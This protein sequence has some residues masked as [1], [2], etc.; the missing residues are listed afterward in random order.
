MKFKNKTIAFILLLSLIFT[1]KAFIVFAETKHSLYND[2]T[3]ITVETTDDTNVTSENENTTAAEENKESESTNETTE[4]SEIIETTEVTETETT[5]TESSEVSNSYKSTTITEE[6]ET[7]MFE[8]TTEEID[9]STTEEEEPEEDITTVAT[10]ETSK[11]L[12]ETDLS[13]ESTTIEETTAKIKNNENLFGDSTPQFKLVYFKEDMSDIDIYTFD[14]AGMSVIPDS[15]TIAANELEALN[16]YD[17]RYNGV[18]DIGLEGDN[19]AWFR[20]NYVWN[21]DRIYSE[22]PISLSDAFN[23]WCTSSTLEEKVYGA[24]YA[25]LSEMTIV[26]NTIDTEYNMGENFNP[27]GLRID[28]KFA[29]DATDTIEYSD[30]TRNRFKFYDNSTGDELTTDTEINADFTLKIVYGDVEHG[31]DAISTVSATI[32][33]IT[34]DPSAE[35]GFKVYCQKLDDTI[36]C[37]NYQNGTSSEDFTDTVRQLINGDSVASDIIAYQGWYYLNTY[38]GN[39]YEAYRTWNDTDVFSFESDFKNKVDEWLDGGKTENKSVGIILQRRQY[40]DDDHGLLYVWHLDSNGTII[41]DEFT[42]IVR[43]DEFDAY[44]DELNNSLPPQYNTITGYYRDAYIDYQFYRPDRRPRDDYPPLRDTFVQWKE[45]PNSFSFH[46]SKKLC[47]AYERKTP[48]SISVSTPPNK[49]TYQ[50]GDHF[51]PEGLIITASYPGNINDQVPCDEF[52]DFLFSFDPTTDV[53]LSTTND[54]ITITCCN[55]SVDLPIYVEPEVTSISICK[56]VNHDTYSV[57]E[58]LDPSGLSININYVDATSRELVYNDENASLFDFNPAL[59]HAYEVSDVGVKSHIITYRS[60][61]TSFNINVLENNKFMVLYEAG[62]VLHTEVLEASASNIESVLD[63]AIQSGYTG[64]YKF[65]ALGYYDSQNKYDKA[66]EQTLTKEQ[67]LLLYKSFTGDENIFIGAVIKAPTPTPPEPTPPEPTPDPTPTPP[68]NPGG[69]GGSSGGSSSPSKGP[70]GDLTKQAIPTQQIV[71]S[72]SLN[73]T[74]NIPQNSLVDNSL[75]AVTLLSVPENEIIPKTNITDVNGNT[76][77]G[78]WLKVP[79]E[80]TWFFLAGD[81]SA[82]GN[83]GTAGFVSNGLYNLSWGTSNGW[84]S[85]DIFGAMQTGWQEINGKRYYFEPNANEASFGMAVV[86]TKTIDGKSYSFDTNGVL[87]Q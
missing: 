13:S 77:F 6:N 39:D 85:F 12:K 66:K 67:A 73:P 65:D 44:I 49:T 72:F 35:K 86:G 15:I 17:K 69:G 46:D 41:R 28:V 36:E 76:G 64:F 5:E 60:K 1:S 21:D 3:T 61:E 55:K 43:M 14:Y 31:N 62:N 79:N 16:Y 78:K 10:T 47:I 82:N 30:D 7:T 40:E 33:I 68:Y 70:M 57:G 50:I 56:M 63:T 26:N 80:N 42:E 9:E 38:S 32:N 24:N 2:E 8:P 23:S 87:I 27:S 20:N 71:P 81:L 22:N 59:D 45:N 83:L 18:V 58:N 74:N 11:E 75:L 4:S 29:N 19:W 25:K 52:R 51:D 84:Y 48:D 34:I 54:K 37:I 53:E